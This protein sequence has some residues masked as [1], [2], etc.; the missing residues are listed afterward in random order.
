MKTLE[1]RS[2]ELPLCVLGLLALAHQQYD[3]ARE[4]A[5]WA[6]SASYGILGHGLSTG[7]THWS[8]THDATE[9]GGRRVDCVRLTKRVA[10]HTGE[11]EPP[12]DYLFP[13]EGLRELVAA[14]LTMAVA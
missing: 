10:F 4:N 3:T 7:T 12:V 14:E 6:G 13:F 8:T 9:A 5:Q 2:V 1:K 11:P